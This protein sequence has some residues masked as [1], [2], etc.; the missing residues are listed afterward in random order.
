VL[1]QA[2]ADDAVRVLAELPADYLTVRSALG[3]A[4]PR[5]VLIVPFTHERRPMGLLELGLLADDTGGRAVELLTRARASLGS[6]FRMA[7]SRQRTRALLDETKRQAEELQLAAD[8]LRTTNGELGRASRYKSEFLANMSHELRTPL[9]SIMILSKILATNEARNLTDKQAEFATMIHRSGDELLAL[10]NDVLDMAKVEAGRQDM[11]YERLRVV[12]LF[13]YTRRMFEP[14]ATQKGLTFDVAIA[15][16]VPGEIQT[17]RARLSQI[18]KNLIA[19]AFKFTPRGGEVRVRVGKFVPAQLP[20]LTVSGGRDAIAITVSDTGIGIPADKQAWIF[21]AFAQ[22]EGGTSRKY[23]GTGLGLTIA[24]QLA[25]RLGGD[26]GVDSEVG[27]GS[28]F[29]VVLPIEGAAHEAEAR[30]AAA[31][32]PAPRGSER[33]VTPAP[34]VRAVLP[35]IADDRAALTAGEPCLLVIEDDPEFATVV[36]DLVREAGFKCLVASEGRPGLEL[37]KEHVPSG[38]VLDVGL[39]DLDGWSVMEMLKAERVT[40]DVPVHFVTATATDGAERAHRMGAVGFMAKPVEAMQLRSALRALEEAGRAGVRKVLLVE[41][42][43]TLRASMQALLVGSEFVVDAVGTPGE[44]AA[45]IAATTYGCVIAN[46]ALPDPAAGFELLAKIRAVPRTAHVPV[47]VHT[48]TTPTVG[49]LCSK[50]RGCS[51]TACAPRCPSAGPA[52]RRRPASR[53]SSTARPCSSSTTT[54]ETCTR[55]R[56]RCARR[57]CA[58]SRR[59]TARKRSTSSRSTPRRARC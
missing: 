10:I 57:T 17:D 48:A 54:C 12:D 46:L 56:A 14:Q 18:V 5:C 30:A 58:C 59:P 39:P 1:G 53:R 41:S 55:C 27:K 33:A 7:E 21:E 28:R 11:V 43:A 26:L 3:K 52:R 35:T 44:A 34:G 38:I 24:K 8:E 42:D 37:A 6:A 20:R 32:A 51:Y 16:D 4:A 49:E 45:R 47:V 31:P 19:N 9:N 36:R 15:D 2:A 29:H 50:R 25:V 13:D 23:G 22:A 40:R